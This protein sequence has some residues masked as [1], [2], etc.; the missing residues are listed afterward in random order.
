[1]AAPA[2][3]E[4]RNA[5]P[6]HATGAALLLAVPVPEPLLAVPAPEPLLVLADADGLTWLLDVVR[7]ATVLGGVGVGEGVPAALGFVPPPGR[8]T[9]IVRSSNTTAAAT[10]RRR[11][12][13]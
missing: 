9:Q 6:L 10:T 8:R 3:A 12:R 1:V 5:L 7:A 13:Q 4:I 2:S 11:R